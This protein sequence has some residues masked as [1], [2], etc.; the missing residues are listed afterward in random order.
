MWATRTCCSG[1]QDTWV[2]ATRD[3]VGDSSIKLKTGAGWGFVVCNRNGDGLREFFWPKKKPWAEQRKLFVHLL[4]KTWWEDWR[5]GEGS[6]GWV[7]RTWFLTLR[8]TLGSLQWAGQT[9]KRLGPGFLCSLLLWWAS[10]TLRKCP[11]QPGAKTR[12]LEQLV[13]ADSSPESPLELAV[14]AKWMEQAQQ[15]R[16]VLME[17]DPSYPAEIEE[18]VSTL[19]DKMDMSTEDIKWEPKAGKFYH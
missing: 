9:W 18:Y 15:R 3:T 5:T 6:Q 11:V 8:I 1:C 10:K 7:T 12:H 2:P 14:Q 17:K 16:S 13:P 4:T 19:L